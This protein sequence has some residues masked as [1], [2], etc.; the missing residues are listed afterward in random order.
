MAVHRQ[1]AV[2]MNMVFGG[3]NAPGTS[4]PSPA[5]PA[6]GGTTGRKTA[7]KAVPATRQP[8]SAVEGHFRGNLSLMGDS[9]GWLSFGRKA[10]R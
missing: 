5:R 1:V 10:V 4:V 9:F 2:C 7:D 6:Y 8:N 3:V